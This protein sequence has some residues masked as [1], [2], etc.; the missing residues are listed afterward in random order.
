MSTLSKIELLAGRLADKAAQENTPV[1]EMTEAL[2]AL[3]PYYTALRKAKGSSDDDADDDT[4]IGGI[5]AELQRVS[6][7]GNGGQTVSGRGR[8]GRNASN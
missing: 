6:E 3:G 4:S 1:S 2:K 5:Q 7:A 8:R